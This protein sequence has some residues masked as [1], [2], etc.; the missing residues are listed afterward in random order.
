VIEL[1][2]EDAPGKGEA[3]T[4]LLAEV[5]P[6]AAIV[7]GDDVSDSSAFGVLRRARQTT[8]LNGL[9][10]AVQ[11]RAEV[12]PSVLQQADI[13]LGS[14]VESA[15]FLTGLARALALRPAS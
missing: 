10:I 8:G 7:L 12:P 5:Q 4:T 11:A 9:A 3:M 2:P 13:V 15:R 14:P 6:S 1:R